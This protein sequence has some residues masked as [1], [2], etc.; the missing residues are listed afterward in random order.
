MQNSDEKKAERIL[1]FLEIF[2]MPLK[3]SLL[4]QIQELDFMF[5]YFL[6]SVL[7]VLQNRQSN[8]I[9]KSSLNLVLSLTSQL[10]IKP[11]IMC[12]LSNLIEV[13]AH[14]IS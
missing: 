1:E 4:H 9:I 7:F 10:P 11:S 12:F 2:L 14:Y 5:E 6:N 8:S 3:S 13:C